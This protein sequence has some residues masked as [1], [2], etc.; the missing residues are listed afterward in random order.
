[1]PTQTETTKF[2]PFMVSLESVY[3]RF[4]WAISHARNIHGFFGLFLLLLPYATI[5]SARIRVSIVY[6][7]AGFWFR[8]FYSSSCFRFDQINTHRMHTHT[9]Q[10][11]T[12]TLTIDRELQSTKQPTQY[13]RSIQMHK[14]HHNRT[15]IKKKNVLFFALHLTVFFVFLNANGIIQCNGLSVCV[16]RTL[17]VRRERLCICINLPIA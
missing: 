12:V 10:W 1:M 7:L 14:L 11:V 6:S 17:Y 5:Y 8:C 2:V 9:R 3:C 15:Q 4:S 16:R 13:Q